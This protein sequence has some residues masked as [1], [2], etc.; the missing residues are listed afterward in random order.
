MGELLYGAARRDSRKL[1]DRV[2]NL[3]ADWLKP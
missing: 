1:T 3:I 2:R